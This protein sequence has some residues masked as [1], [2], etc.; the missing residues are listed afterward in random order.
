MDWRKNIIHPLICWKNKEKY[1]Q[2][3]KILQETQ[4][5][6]HESIQQEKLSK[7]SLVLNEAYANTKYYR[8]QFEQN[9]IG[10][11]TISAV[12]DLMKY[13]KLRKI[14]IQENIED[15]IS[16]RYDK[17][18]LIKD[19]TGG[20]TGSPLEFYYDADRLDWRTAST[21]RH[22]LWAGYEM[23]TKAAILWGARTDFTGLK[24]LK[25][26]IYKFL[27]SNSIV[28]DAS[29]ITEEVFAQFTTQLIS[30][31]P[32]IIQAYARTLFLYVQYLVEKGITP[33]QP[34]GIITSAEVLSSAERTLI[35]SV[36]RAKVFNRYGCRE[37]AVLASE[38]SHGNMHINDECY[39]LEFLRED[40]SLCEYGEEGEIF[41]TDLLNYAMPM[42]RYCIGDTGIPLEGPCPCGMGLSIM[43]I[44]SGR[45]TDFIHTPT[46]K[47]V[48]GVAVATYIIT[49][50][51]GLG[52]VQFYQDDKNRVTVK[53]VKNNK[54][55]EQTLPQLDSNIKS[56]L[57][58]I[59]T[60]FELVDSIPRT[61]TG[62]MLFCVSTLNK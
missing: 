56:I 22:D 49:R 12:E 44:A 50:I 42:I 29:S 34:K 30:F 51:D 45:V 37:F 27:C 38:C 26:K 35:E 5:L 20:S 53:V 25:G 60:N 61:E 23:D 11:M 8:R 59:E 16:T 58:G 17:Y 57:D 36:F 40:G 39:H 21:R 3:L 1:L 14:D 32:D 52:Q 10:D 55:N 24:S 9:G 6:S 54:F 15:M 19:K 47:K 4:F 41:V 31:K 18:L 13:P 28:L 43:K 2:Y 62:K 46:G 7:L 33:P 48:S